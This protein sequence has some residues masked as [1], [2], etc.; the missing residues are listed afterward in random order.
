MEGLR[1]YFY[2]F[3]LFSRNY[4]S[5]VRSSNFPI[6]NFNDFSPIDFVIFVGVRCATYVRA[7]KQLSIHEAPNIMTIVLKR[8]QVSFCYG[9]LLVLCYS[10]GNFQ[11]LKN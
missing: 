11:F 9:V 6:Y 2:C 5:L 7:R 1:S 3:I 8:F 4:N 10:F